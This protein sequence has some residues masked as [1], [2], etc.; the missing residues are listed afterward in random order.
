MTRHGRRKSPRPSNAGLLPINSLCCYCTI[1][2]RSLNVLSI[3]CAPLCLSFYLSLTPFRLI[4]KKL[5]FLA[6]LQDKFYAAPLFHHCLLEQVLR[7]RLR[8][9]IRHRANEF[10]LLMGSEA[11]HW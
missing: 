5:I 1:A 7:K 8:E 9:D 6:M 10:C 3:F 4:I 11:I 2:E